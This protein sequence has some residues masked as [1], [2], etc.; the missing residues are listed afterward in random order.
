MLQPM[1]ASDKQI[2]NLPVQTQ[3]EVFIGYVVGF[4]IDVET[5]SIAKYYVAKHK[6]VPEVIRSLVGMEL[7]EVAPSQVLAILVDKMIVQ[8]TVHLAHQSILSRWFRS[9]E[10]PAA[11]P[12][13]SSAAKA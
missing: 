4:E 13:L 7:L 9:A 2:I 3:L 8:D 6:L 12:S 5:H 1:R 11:T 10:V